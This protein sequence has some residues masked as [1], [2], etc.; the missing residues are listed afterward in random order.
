[1][2]LRKLTIDNSVKYVSKG[3]TL[4]KDF[5][6]KTASLPENH[7]KKLSQNNIKFVEDIVTG[8]GFGMIE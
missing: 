2:T 3:N 6:P 7:N 5:K 8:E 1:M 4:P